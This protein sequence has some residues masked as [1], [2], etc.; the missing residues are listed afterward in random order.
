MTCALS[1]TG[2][3]P[4]FSKT[5]GNTYATIVASPFPLQGKPT[6]D[7]DVALWPSRGFDSLSLPCL[8]V[9]VGTALTARAQIRGTKE[10]PY[11]TTLTT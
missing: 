1:P 11:F 2:L 10:R 4:W 5:K 7:Q 6:Q 8:S 9:A 3:I